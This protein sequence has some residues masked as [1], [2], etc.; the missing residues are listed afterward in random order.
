MLIKDMFERDIDRNINGVV[1]I[2]END[3]EQTRALA[4]QELSEYVVTEELRSHFDTF[5]SAYTRAFDNPTG[6]MGVWIS[7]FFG[8]GK[9]HFLKMLSYLL[10][11]KEAGGKKAI[12]YL[13][14]R[15]ESPRIS[16]MAELACSVPTETILFNID[17]KGP[18]Q[19]DDTAVLKVFA[20]VFYEHLGFFGNNLKLARLERVIA[21]RGKTEQFRAAFQDIMDEA[22][23]D[24][25]ESYDFFGDEVAEAMERAGVTSKENALR[26]IEGND[27]V[28]FSIDSLTDEIAA[29]AKRRA[30]EEGGQFRLLFMIDEVGQYISEN[31]SLMLNLQTMVED[32][33]KKCADRVWVV[34][35]SQQAIDEVTNVVGM[36]FSKI[37]GRFDTRLSLSSEGAGEV[38]RRR[39]LAKTP[40][41]AN[42]LRMVY[43]DKEMVLKNLFTFNNATA[44]LI[45]YRDAQGFV[46]A[47]PFVGYQFSL[48]QNIIN[49][50]RNQGTSGKHL[51]A[52]RSM[53]AGFKEAAQRVKDLDEGTLIPLWMFYDTVKDFLE[54]YHR[55]V[56]VRAERA[57]AN[58]DGLEPFDAR[59]LKLL[60]L[61][62]WVNREM[63]GTK[64]NITTLMADAIDV[65]RAAL[66]E[67]V[68]AS[69]E[70]L[71]KQ[72]YITRT[73]EAY[74]FLTDDE[75][76][77]ADQI[78][79]TQVDIAHLTSY[80]S[81]IVFDN[82]YSNNKL[83]YGKNLFTLS[84]YLDDTLKGNPGSL[85]VRVIAGMNG[86]E[87]ETPQSLSMRSL[88]N[89][90]IIALNPDSDY[91]DDLVEAARIKAYADTAP[92]NSMTESQRSVVRAKQNESNALFNRAREAMELAIRRGSF[93][94][95]GSSITPEHTS[96]AKAIIEDCAGRLVASVYP[97]LSCITENYENDAQITQILTGKAP[98]LEGMETNTLAIE[99]MRSYLKLNAAH[100]ASVSVADL[101]SHFQNAPY[102]W[103]EQDIAAVAA[104]LINQGEAK[105][106]YGGQ[107]VDATSTHAVDHLRKA[108]RT[109]QTTIEARVHVTAASISKVRSALEALCGEHNLPTT[110][111][112]LAAAARE[113]LASRLSG[114]EALLSGE[115]Q[116]CGAYPGKR[117][118]LDAV[119]DIENALN[120]PGDSSD[121]LNAI[122]EHAGD[123]S[124]D[125]EDLEQID[126]FFLNQK[127]PFD[128]TLTL[129]SKI[130]NEQDELAIDPSVPEHIATLKSVT[131]SMSP[132]RDI[133][134][135]PGACSHIDQVYGRLLEEKRNDVLAQIEEVFATIEN[136]EQ[137]T[138][139]TIP[140]VAESKRS[141]INTARTAQTLTALNAVTG[142]LQADQTRLVTAI[143]TE[144]NRIH[145]PRP[146]TPDV[147]V[148]GEYH[149]TPAPQPRISNVARTLAFVPKTLRSAADIDAYLAE[150]RTRLLNALE[151]NDAITLN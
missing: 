142:R 55:R 127:E 37:Q 6:K 123:L 62:R 52:E 10:S 110:E 28:D 135:L 94:V 30:E 21:S 14:P 113:T 76:E 44:D 81:D 147:T 145:R 115:Y 23:E 72:N 87:P 31:T 64:D 90:A 34:V 86:A 19:K 46:D 29:Y 99:E 79:R 36:D 12:D 85:T 129:L 74:L 51:S 32:L 33:G 112:E 120:T 144:H 63:P 88:S 71:I 114:L 139:T 82:I 92:I 2:N 97:K 53:L 133:S 138:N 119:A 151:G 58:N 80:A 35:T 101:Q 15:F 126:G 102:G 4:I 67:R 98:A 13:S 41:A 128:R 104:R 73:G 5:L 66:S 39:I 18:S 117:V 95:K 89:E 50:L 77:V 61:I 27:E 26:W 91:Y 1:T 108:T 143:Q 118:V 59:V 146:A 7:G 140:Q 103:R 122:A 9:S 45:G 150:A 60:F 83:S 121:L 40:D 47:F 109:R 125:A 78:K 70:R 130:E 132:Y 106:M 56:I 137:E 38:I 111:D 93:Y 42:L 11:G 24:S 22:W 43:G 75:R 49:S 3:D 68:A 141:R 116:R 96:S 124:D 16:H 20:R 149:S 57:A 105:L 107:P 54:D 48:M 17:S 100:H 25:R 69:L 134:K 8:S 148:T 136:F 65:D 131:S 84:R